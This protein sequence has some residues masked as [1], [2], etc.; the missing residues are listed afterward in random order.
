MPQITP[1]IAACLITKGD[2]E[3][4]TLKITIA[5]VKPYVDDIFITSS[6]ENKE[7]VKWCKEQGIHHS[8]RAWDK[9]F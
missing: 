5:S 2:E 4:E 9:D 8:F 6:A 1:K 3:L 7:L